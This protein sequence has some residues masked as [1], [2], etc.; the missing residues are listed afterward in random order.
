MFWE[1]VTPDPSHPDQALHFHA[2]TEASNHLNLNWA[3]CSNLESHWC[4]LVTGPA[5]LKCGAVSWRGVLGNNPIFSPQHSLFPCSLGRVCWPS[6]N[7]GFYQ[8]Q[9]QQTQLRRQWEFGQ[10]SSGKVKAA[11]VSSSFQ[12]TFTYPAGLVTLCPKGKQEETPPLSPELSSP[13][14]SPLLAPGAPFPVPGAAPWD[15]A[16]QGAPTCPTEGAGRLDW[17]YPTWWM[18]M[19]LLVGLAGADW[20]SEEVSRMRWGRALTVAWGEHTGP[21]QLDTASPGQAGREGAL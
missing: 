17:T 6:V 1:P 14:P 12:L 2:G 9:E 13:D 16:G 7:P 3:C 8:L 15:G 4:T 10:H 19:P 5:D 20:V 18:C 21:E 11:K